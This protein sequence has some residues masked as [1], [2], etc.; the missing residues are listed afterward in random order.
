MEAT[1]KHK[2]GHLSIYSDYETVTDTRDLISIR[3][4]IEKTQAS[5]YTQQRYITIDKKNE[6]LLTLK[7][8][9]KDL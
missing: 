2:K 4:N 5:S 1:S 3:R 6:I 8:L 9:F 7:S